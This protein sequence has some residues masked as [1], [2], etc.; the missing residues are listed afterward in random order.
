M[1]GLHSLSEAP[2]SSLFSQ[3]G[4]VGT[5]TVVFSQTGTILATGKLLGNSTLVFS[6]TGSLSF[7]LTDL[8]GIW[9]NPDGLNIYFGVRE[10]NNVP[11]SLKTF[12]ADP[13]GKLKYDVKNWTRYK[14]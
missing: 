1:L 8:T 13:V 5:A 7:S 3:G 9:V 2:L 4:I 10:Q 12:E 6:Q 14:V 11:L